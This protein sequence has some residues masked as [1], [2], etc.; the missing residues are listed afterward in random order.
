[1]QGLVHA[2]ASRII[3]IDTN[4]AKFAQAMQW[5]ATECLNPLD[6]GDKTIQQVAIRCPRLRF[7]IGW[8]RVAR[9]ATRCVIGCAAA[10]A[11]SDGP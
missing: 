8:K 11:S 7:I 4:P 5:G 3:A 6:C 1:M 10:S 2:K 9:L